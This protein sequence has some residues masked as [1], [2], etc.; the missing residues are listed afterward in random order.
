MVDMET[1]LLYLR[2][3]QNKFQ[4]LLTKRNLLMGYMGTIGMEGDKLFHS[5]MEV[6]RELRSLQL[7]FHIIEAEIAYWEHRN[8]MQNLTPETIEEGFQKIIADLN[9]SLEDKKDD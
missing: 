3:A 9:L 7:R 5:T 8:V 4:A 6:L 1:A 2:A